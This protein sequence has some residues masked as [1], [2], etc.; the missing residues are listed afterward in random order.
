MYKNTL[1]P[2]INCRVLFYHFKTIFQSER[3]PKF[4]SSKKI[5][6]KNKMKVRGKFSAFKLY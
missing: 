5:K 6:Y 4:T 2:E 3:H 1:I